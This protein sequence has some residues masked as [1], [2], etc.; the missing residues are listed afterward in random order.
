MLEYVDLPEWRGKVFRAYRASGPEADLVIS[1]W[2]LQLG[3]G[4]QVHIDEGKDDLC[5]LAGMKTR[6]EYDLA[7]PQSVWDELHASGELE[8]RGGA[9]W[10]YDPD[11]G[12][13]FG[14]LR[15]VDEL[16][17]TACRTLASL[18]S[19]VLDKVVVHKM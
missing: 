6:G 5:L 18:L 16:E 4:W 9:I 13:I 17:K 2:Y 7:L 19:E 15:F 11:K 8:R 1:G 3:D 14:G 12:G 10:W